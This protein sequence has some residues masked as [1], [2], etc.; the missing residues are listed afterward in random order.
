M[1][2]WKLT[3]GLANLRR[4]IDEAFPG[5]D[6]ASDGTIGDAAHRTHASGHNPDDTPGSRPEWDGDPDSTPEVRSWDMDSDLHAAPANAQQVVDHIRKLPGVS[7]QLR[8]MIYKRK[9][10]RAANG[11]KPETYTG[12]SAH[13]EHVHFSGAY[14]QS[15]D[16][17]T[18]FDYHLEEI[19]VSLTAADKTWLSSTIN[20]AVNK[21]V[22][23][24]AEGIAE[25]PAEVLVEKIGDKANPSRTVGDVLRDVAKLRGALVGDPKDTA[26]AAIPASAPIA[27]L[28]AAADVVLAKK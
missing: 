2:N 14:A 24:L 17:D 12:P 26:N 22:T 11:W 27:R 21:A 15:A 13:T 6:R 23:Q 19:P 10:Y 5:R 18:T 1:P 25:L 8:Y 7:T 16:N 20:T 28:T 3:D 4:Q 9:I